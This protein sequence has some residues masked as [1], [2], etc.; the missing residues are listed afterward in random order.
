MPTVLYM[1]SESSCKLINPISS[2]AYLNCQ[3][4]GFISYHVVNM[5]L[6]MLVF[7]HI[8][9]INGFISWNTLAAALNYTA[10]C[11]FY[12]TT[13][14]YYSSVGCC[15]ALF[16]ILLETT[17]ATSWLLATLL[18]ASYSPTTTSWLSKL[19]DFDLQGSSNHVAVVNY[20][21]AIFPILYVWEG[22]AAC[23]YTFST[24]CLLSSCCFFFCQI[25]PLLSSHLF[26]RWW[27]CP[28]PYIIWNMSWWW[29]TCE[30]LGIISSR[31]YITFSSLLY[32]DA[33]MLQVQDQMMIDMFL[34]PL[35]LLLLF[36]IYNLSL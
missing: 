11:Y 6:L 18:T 5:V 9:L 16:P 26:C 15:S 1:H 32:Y 31:S 21:L 34:R 20:F 4:I 10:R 7:Y 24:L 12:T 29:R 36:F 23:F 27:N 28:S 8:V 13:T 2:I 19:P 3:Q 33:L 35:P 17:T 25:S 22:A 30:E 14:L